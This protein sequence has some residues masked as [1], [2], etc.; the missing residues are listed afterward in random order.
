MGFLHL[1]LGWMNGTGQITSIF[2]LEDLMPRENLHWGQSTAIA[3]V[4]FRQS[5][6]H[7]FTFRRPMIIVFSDIRTSLDSVDR[8]ALWCC[9]LWNGVPEKYVSVP[10]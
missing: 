8:C 1:Y 7:R 5:L 10:K 9:L 4:T 2:V 6:E 3:I